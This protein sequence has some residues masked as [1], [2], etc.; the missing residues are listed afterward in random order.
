MDVINVRQAPNDDSVTSRNRIAPASSVEFLAEIS[1]S[2]QTTSVS[3]KRHP[4][5]QAAIDATRTFC[6]ESTIHGLVY[7]GGR[8]SVGWFWR[9]VWAGVIVACFSWAAVIIADSYADWA[10][11]PVE[12]IIVDPVYHVSHVQARTEL[13]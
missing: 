8:L 13:Y 11:H 3:S 10:A 2:K 4:R 1:S 6:E 7:I 9:L 5:L 12:T